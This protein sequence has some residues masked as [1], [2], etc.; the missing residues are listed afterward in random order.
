MKQYT[1]NV[2]CDA[3]VV[4]AVEADSEQEALE[5][6]KYEFQDVP[7]ETA[8]INDIECCVTDIQELD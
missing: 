5:L 8:F 7:L 3:I 1:V 2:H 6:A 4:V